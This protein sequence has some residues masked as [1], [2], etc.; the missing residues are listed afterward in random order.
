MRL[1][2]RVM[3]R[4]PYFRFFPVLLLIGL[5]AVP[6]LAEEA[7]DAALFMKGRF[8]AEEGR[9][10][11]A[12]QIFDRLVVKHEKNPVLHFERAKVLSQLKQFRRAEESLR[13]AIDLDPG[14]Y[15]A[16]KL[17]GR[18]LLDR[19]GGD[20]ARIE[21][22]LEQLTMSYQLQPNDL[23]TALTITQVLLGLG[24]MDDAKLILDGLL[25]RMP[26]HRSV[27]YQYA[28][29]LL[30]MN[31]K[32]E[33]AP[34]L[35]K[36]ILQEP[37]YRP[38]ISQ[39]LEIYEEQGNWSGAADLLGTLEMQEPDNREIRRQRAYLLL[40]AERFEESR[41]ILDALLEGDPNDAAST[42]ML[43]EVLSELRLHGE[44]EEHYRKALLIRPD[45]PELLVSFGL[46]QLALDDLDTAEA[47][48]RRLLELDDMP[49][50]VRAMAATQLAAID[51]ERGNY[52]DALA[53]ARGVLQT[54]GIVN[55]Q[56]VN[57]TLD[58]LRRNE[59]YD[60][61]LRILGDLTRG[62][63]EAP[64]LNARK[65]EFLTLAGDETNAQKVARQQAVASLESGLTAAQ[66]YAQMERFEDVLDVLKAMDPRWKEEID[67]LFQLGAANERTGKTEA[68]EAAFQQVLDRN[69]DHAP[70]LNYLGYMWADRG[71]RL[72]EAEQLISKAV[73]QYP[74]N[75]AYVD[76]LGWVYYKLGRYDLAEK[77]LL[78][79]AGLIP[80]DPTI[81]EHLGDLFVR[82]G[83]L[84]RAMERYEQ[85]L[86]LEPDDESALRRKMNELEE[87]LAA[88]LEQ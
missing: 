85:A 23:A 20:R 1:L 34:Y 56:A 27:V 42:F 14:F 33:A 63:E 40:R 65:I 15:D 6:V 61:A 12:L 7:E 5:C 54:E 29:V 39:L 78:D 70:T 64:V 81:Q 74:K 50:R 87:K 19:S 16:R 30:R 41:G 38:A 46:N 77:H 86:E 52:D 82:L 28:Q 69:P 8:A 66:M 72:D 73:E 10:D 76:S 59:E 26:D 3:S 24:R 75:G 51:H 79:A 60:D 37:Y 68:A 49:A 88:R 53:R 32:D 31:R 11:D 57:I 4:A 67:Y 35:E 62:V 2:R 83:N 84:E 13:E 43:A 21:E 58:V 55:L 47:Q 36:V 18:M 25:E 48:F 44:A 22:A 9:L 45:D 71:V 80:D 17:L